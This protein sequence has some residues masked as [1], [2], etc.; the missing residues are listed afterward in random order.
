MSTH[1]DLSNLLLIDSVQKAAMEAEL[2]RVKEENERLKQMLN[3]VVAHYNTLHAHFISLIQKNNRSDGQ[4]MV[5]LF[6]KLFRFS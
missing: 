3:Q 5:K 2:V 4:Q 1:R 6:F